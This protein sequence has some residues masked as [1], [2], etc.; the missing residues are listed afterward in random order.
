MQSKSATPPPCTTENTTATT[1][2]TESGPRKSKIWSIADTLASRA[3]AANN[4]KESEHIRPST[5]KSEDCDSN[6]RSPDYSTSIGAPTTLSA[7]AAA[8]APLLQ[9]SNGVAQQSFLQFNPW[10]QQQLAALAMARMPFP[11]PDVL[12]MMNQMNQ[13]RPPMLFNPV[14]M[15]TMGPGAPLQSPIQ[16]PPSCMTSS[17]PANTQ[18]NG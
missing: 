1:T 18:T 10:Q 17:S 16:P 14:Y 6:G 15:G 3:E 4:A 11:R 8:A 2:T 7:A 13:I 9:P 5:S 12:A